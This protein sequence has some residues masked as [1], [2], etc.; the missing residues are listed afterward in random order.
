VPNT[1]N[2]SSSNFVQ[3]YTDSTGMANAAYYYAV[4]AVGSSQS[5]NSY[6]LG[7]GLTGTLRSTSDIGPTQ[8][9]GLTEFANST[10]GLA[11]AGRGFVG[12]TDRF[13]YAWVPINGGVT[14]TARVT[15]LQAVSPSTQAGIDLRESLDP[16]A[17]H[18][19]A[20]LTGSLGAV[21]LARAATK[22][23]TSVVG[24]KTGVQPTRWIRLSRK[25]DVFTASIAPDGVNW[26]VI[27]QT[28]IK[29]TERA[30]IGLAVSSTTPGTTAI[31]L[32]DHIRVSPGG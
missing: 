21:E 29:M 22:G 20:A 23:T 17:P 13:H 12:P 5:D 18:A 4:S 27:G 6:E 11:S 31:A 26:T 3:T 10:Y 16:H 2:L 19:L 7:V 9:P 8:V 28:T 14:M 25:G 15:Y 30:F 24:R 32:F 1:T